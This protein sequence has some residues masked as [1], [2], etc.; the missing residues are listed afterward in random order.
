[1]DIVIV[2]SEKNGVRIFVRVRES[3]VRKGFYFG[4]I[5]EKVGLIIDGLGGGY[6]GVVG[7]NGK[8]NF[9]DVIKLIFKEIEKFLREVG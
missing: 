4:K 3:F 6:V 2:G 1:M 8:K 9:D 5:M 7:V